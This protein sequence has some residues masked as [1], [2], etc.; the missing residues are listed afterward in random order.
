MKRS[1]P[2]LDTMT[3]DW[4]TTAGPVARKLVNGDPAA[5]PHTMLL[6]SQPRTIPE[7]K[8]QYHGVAEEFLCLEGGFTFDGTIWMRRF[9][10]AYYPAGTVHGAHVVVPDG[11]LMYLRFA[12]SVTTQPVPEPLQT[13]AYTTAMSPEGEAVTILSDALPTGKGPGVRILRSDPTTGGGATMVRLGGCMET[14]SQGRPGP[15]EIFVVQGSVEANDCRHFGPGFYAYDDHVDA[16]AIRASR[17]A[18]LI[19][20]HAGP[21]TL[22][23]A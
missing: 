7:S 22:N 19:V 17:D 3:L 12:G 16:V 2:L 23:G 20:H 11:Y 6:R 15:L 8:A 21:L 1:I 5:G 18:V 4:Q 13:S 10:Y 14:I 9:S